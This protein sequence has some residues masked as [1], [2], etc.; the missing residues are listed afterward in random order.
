M[1]E[2]HTIQD[3]IPFYIAS[4]FMINN[5]RKKRFNHES[6]YLCDY[7][8]DEIT[9]HNGPKLL[10][11]SNMFVFGDESEER[12]IKRRKNPKGVARIP[13]KMPL[14]LLD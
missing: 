6:H 10:W 14:F 9:R 3:M 5:K 2:D 13:N 11:V 4:L 1:Y 7:L 12:N 8:V